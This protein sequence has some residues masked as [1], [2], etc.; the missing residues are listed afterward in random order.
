MIHDGNSVIVN[1]D[2][3]TWFVGLYCSN[4]CTV[5][6]WI[7]TGFQRGIQ[8]NLREIGIVLREASARGWQME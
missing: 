6:N 4:A 5:K 7:S 2:E 3:S 1:L 8:A